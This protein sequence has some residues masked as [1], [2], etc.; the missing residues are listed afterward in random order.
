MKFSKI[1]ILILSLSISVGA[2]VYI[3]SNVTTASSILKVDE[4]LVKPGEKRDNALKDINS[5]KKEK[6]S[7]LKK[8]EESEDENERK[9][10]DSKLIDL[11]IQIG[12]LE[13]ATD[14]YDYKSFLEVQLNTLDAVIYDYN[15][16]LKPTLEGL[17]LEDQ[18][19]NKKEETAK[20]MKELEKVQEKY[21][22]V[23]DKF[24]DNINLR[25]V[26]EDFQKDLDAVNEKYN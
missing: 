4:E 22:G 9:Q 8:L 7:L 13:V 18:K 12:Q 1:V 19:A 17:S 14:T 10:I 6:E 26:L 11:T 3:N 5:L 25:Q 16:V 2:L 24:D 15:N 20:R 21:K 23:L